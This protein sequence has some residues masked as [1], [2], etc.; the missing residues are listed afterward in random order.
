MLTFTAHI[1]RPECEVISEELHDERRVFVTLLVQCVELCDGFIKCLLSQRT[2]PTVHSKTVTC[3]EYYS[4]QIFLPYKLT[5]TSQNS[6]HLALCYRVQQ[7]L[8][9][10]EQ[11]WHVNQTSWVL[12]VHWSQGFYKSRKDSQTHKLRF[13]HTLPYLSRIPILTGNRT[14]HD[15]WKQHHVHVH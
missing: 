15:I 12:S 13:S 7:I 14:K 5:Y 1:R 11:I 3:C 9:L 2:S 8:K 10:M 6:M 4:A